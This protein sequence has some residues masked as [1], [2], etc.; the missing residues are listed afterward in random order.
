MKNEKK[1]LLIFLWVGSP[2]LHEM[3]LEKLALIVISTQCLVA[4]HA[5]F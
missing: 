3:A 5:F 1:M 2:D 4:K